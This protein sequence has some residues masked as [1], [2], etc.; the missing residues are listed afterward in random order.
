MHSQFATKLLSLRP[1]VCIAAENIYLERVVYNATTP[2]GAI[3][4]SWFKKKPPPSNPLNSHVIDITYI[5]MESSYFIELCSARKAITQC[6]RAC[7]GW[8][9]TYINCTG[10]KDNRD[11]VPTTNSNHSN[12]H[13]RGTTISRPA[14]HRKKGH[15][16][17]GA[18]FNTKAGVFIKLLLEKL[19]RMLG[20][21][22]KVNLLLTKL[23]SRLCHYPHPLLTSFLLNHNVTLV[24]AVPDLPLVSVV[25]SILS[26]GGKFTR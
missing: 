11:T 3:G 20:Q 9:N 19:S 1:S 16:S 13:R 4:G 23:I 17:S 22:P 5:S 21:P 25:C 12:I 2:D 10:S 24:Q 8:S 6:G 7:K 26:F 18:Q 15:S 14:A